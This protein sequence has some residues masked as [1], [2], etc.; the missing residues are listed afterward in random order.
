MSYPPVIPANGL[1]FTKILHSD[2]YPAID[3]TTESKHSGHAIFITGASSGIGLATAH[4]FAKAGASYIGLASLDPFP[5]TI[6]TSLH[7]AAALGNH[8]PPKL[9]ILHLDVLD[10]PSIDTAVSHISATFNAK[11]DVLINCAGYMAPGASIAASDDDAYWRTF[12][13]NLRGTYRVTKAFLPLVLQD[14]AGL[15]TVVNISSVAAHNLRCEYSSYGI[16]KNAILRFTEFLMAEN[17]EA[18]LLAYCVH[19]GA[20]LTRLA[21]SMP[22][23]TL[24]GLKDTPEMAADTLVYLTQGRREWLAGRYLSCTWDLPELLAREDEIVGGD[25]LKMRMVL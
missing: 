24:A 8:P 16:S 4:S 18:G 20:V 23:D 5:S 6:T 3:P 11:L 10:Q 9:S 2:T 25:K 21:E 1:N 22:R 15:K 12:E 19:P 14:T 13:V 17:A 7:S